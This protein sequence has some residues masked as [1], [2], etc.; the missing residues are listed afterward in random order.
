MSG[1]TIC[2]ERWHDVLNAERQA[3]P[4]GPGAGDLER[5]GYRQVFAG[6]C[7]GPSSLD[8]HDDWHRSQPV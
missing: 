6:R 3:V 2:A 8:R 5:D 1:T 7:G 4:C